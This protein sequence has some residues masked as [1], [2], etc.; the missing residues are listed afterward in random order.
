MLST[1]PAITRSHE[2]RAILPAARA[3]ASRPEA[4]YRLICSPGTWSAKPAVIGAIR[5]SVADC[6]PAPV[7]TPRM[8]SSTLSGASCERSLIAARVWVISSIGVISCSAPVGLPRPR[9]VRTWS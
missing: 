5:L 1:P 6:S 2:P 8:T 3:T 7:T 9:G 4:Q